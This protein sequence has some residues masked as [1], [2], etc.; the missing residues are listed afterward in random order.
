MGMKQPQDPSPLSTALPSRCRQ[1][2]VIA[3]A[4]IGTCLERGLAEK[5]GWLSGLAREC[6]EETAVRTGVK[7][8]R[9]SLWKLVP[10]LF[11]EEQGREQAASSLLGP[12]TKK[13]G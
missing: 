11:A 13:S 5:C 1:D 8:A 3:D 7:D 9:S 12:A 6:R 10:G 4:T 2:A